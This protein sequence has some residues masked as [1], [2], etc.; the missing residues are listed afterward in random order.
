MCTNLEDNRA[1]RTYSRN[2]TKFTKIHTTETKDNLN[3]WQD[4]LFAWVVRYSKDINHS[5]IDL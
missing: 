2:I 5:H 1:T 4:V 3:K